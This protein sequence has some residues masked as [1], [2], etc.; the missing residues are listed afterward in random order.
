MSQ[1]L[2]AREKKNKKKQQKKKKKEKRKKEGKLPCRSAV[3]R[4]EAIG[5][6]DV[7]SGAATATSSPPASI[8]TTS[9]NAGDVQDFA[10]VSDG[11]SDG[12]S[13]LWGL[14][15][16]V[17]GVV[18]VAV[19]GWT[20]ACSVGPLLNGRELSAAGQR[21]RTVPLCHWSLKSSSSTPLADDD[22]NDSVDAITS[23]SLL[24]GSSLSVHD[25]W[26][27]KFT[28][29]AECSLSLLAAAGGRMA[30]AAAAATV[31]SPG[32]QWKCSRCTLLT[33]PPCACAALAPP[34]RSITAASSRHL[35]VVVGTT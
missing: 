17:V 3:G 25:K 23:A 15:S 2:S 8:Q 7:R 20:V 19:V 26:R 30:E 16:T 33:V 14:G 12:V 32:G 5:E 27:P 10:S 31:S 21:E 28:G 4:P 34:P 1:W 24:N 18:V 9:V 22:I 35:A 29:G 11:V 6:G 13:W